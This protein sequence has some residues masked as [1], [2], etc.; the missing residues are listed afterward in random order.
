M[1]WRIDHPEDEKLVTV[2]VFHNQ[3]E[4]LLARSRLESAGIE[5]FSRNEHMARIAGHYTG[6]FGMHQI[7]LQVREADAEDAL[8]MLESEVE[9]EDEPEEQQ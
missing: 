1:A 4:F 7:E 3:A 9:T 5:C 6:V 2:G 8:A